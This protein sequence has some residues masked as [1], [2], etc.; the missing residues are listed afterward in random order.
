M[1]LVKYGNGEVWFWWWW[2]WPYTMPLNHKSRANI[3][4][5]HSSCTLLPSPKYNLLDDKFLNS[6]YFGIHQHSLCKISLGQREEAK[7]E[8]LISPLP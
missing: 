7:L 4:A 3:P 8:P 6:L 2:R 5:S 1:T